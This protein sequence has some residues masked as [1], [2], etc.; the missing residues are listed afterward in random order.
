[1]ANK[2]ATDPNMQSVAID[3]VQSGDILFFD[4]DSTGD[5]DHI[6][7]VDYVHGIQQITQNILQLMALV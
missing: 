7:I 1:M 3:E 6:A 4:W 5:C 2:W